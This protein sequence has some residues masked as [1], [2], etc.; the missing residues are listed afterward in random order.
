MHAPSPIR[1]ATALSLA[2][3]GALFL[4]FG[5]YT[6]LPG[7]VDSVPTLTLSVSMDNGT[8]SEQQSAPRDPRKID[9]GPA[10]KLVTA[11]VADERPSEITPDDDTGR[12]DPTPPPAR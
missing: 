5:A 4:I 3:H 11:L 10:E 9:S 1:C 12:S 7:D 8:D 6:F 2:G